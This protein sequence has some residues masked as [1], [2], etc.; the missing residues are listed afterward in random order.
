MANL[1]RVF[2]HTTVTVVTEV[3]A[4]NETE[5]YEKAVNDLFDLDSYAGNGGTDKLIGVSGDCQSVAA[6]EEITYD[7]IV[8]LDSDVE[9]DDEGE[10]D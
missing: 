7:D 3:I 2:G 9:D 8:L 6:D 10:D 1:Y 5:A 4:D